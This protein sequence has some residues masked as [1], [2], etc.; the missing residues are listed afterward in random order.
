MITG[1]AIIIDIKAGLI[2]SL[3]SLSLEMFSSG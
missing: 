1:T 3:E 2:S